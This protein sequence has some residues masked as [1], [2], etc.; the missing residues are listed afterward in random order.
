MS[1]LNYY[2]LLEILLIMNFFINWSFLKLK[3]KLKYKIN[4]LKIKNN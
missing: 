3:Y 4:W 1:T 2:N